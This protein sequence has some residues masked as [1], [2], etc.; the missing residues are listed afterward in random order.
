[1]SIKVPAEVGWVFA[2]EISSDFFDGRRG[3][4]LIGR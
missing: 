2:V 1:M 4:F 3:I